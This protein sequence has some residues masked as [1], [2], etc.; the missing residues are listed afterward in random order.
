MCW[1]CWFDGVKEGVYWG[2]GG[3]MVWLEMLHPFRGGLKVGAY[4][5]SRF[6][7][8]CTFSVFDG[9]GVWGHWVEV[10]SMA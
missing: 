8:L 4:Q 2:L 6:L 5:P 10:L 1:C 3:V 9:S 7:R